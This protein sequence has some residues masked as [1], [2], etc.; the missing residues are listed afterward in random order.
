[1]FITPLVPVGTPTSQAWQSDPDVPG[2][3]VT[4]F[5]YSRDE[6]DTV[7]RDYRDPTGRI[8]RTQTQMFKRYV[9]A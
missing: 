8:L 1:M 9:W 5:D 7:L 6:V 2:G 3:T 4:S